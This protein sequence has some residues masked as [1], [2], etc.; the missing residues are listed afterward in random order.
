MLTTSYIRIPDLRIFEIMRM[1]AIFEAYYENGP[2]Q[3]FIDD[4]SRKDGVFLVRRK[5]DDVVVG[6]S[7][8]AIC[9]FEHEGRQVQGLFSGDTVIEKEYW[10]SRTLQSAFA[11]KLLLEALKRPLSKQYWLLISK[12]YKTY[13]LMARNLPLYYPDR[14][15]EHPGF[16]AMVV[17]YCDQLFPG[18]LNHD[19]MVLDFGQNANC[20]KDNVAQITDELRQRDPDIAFFEARNPEWTRGCE[21]PCIAQVDLWTYLKA[22]GPFIR[23][24]LAP[25]RR[26]AGQQDTATPQQTRR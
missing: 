6:F 12:G 17:A 8:L 26:A 20:L 15:R 19:T 1:H 21:L 5:S 7:T 11:R 10:G 23:K 24:V 9:R 16:R 2:I 14:R 3:V 22:L 25:R 18:K 4:L 13:L